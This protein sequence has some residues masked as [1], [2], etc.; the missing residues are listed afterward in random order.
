M[1]IIRT[2]FAKDSNTYI[3]GKV[4]INKCS[5]CKQITRQRNDVVLLQQADRW[6]CMNCDTYSD[7][8][9]CKCGH[10]EEHPYNKTQY[11]EKDITK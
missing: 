7:V 1:S 2:F 4:R 11:T 10:C 3:Q 9:P 6:V 8:N 5:H